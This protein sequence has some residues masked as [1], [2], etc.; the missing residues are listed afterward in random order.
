[1][2]VNCHP[3]G[4][5]LSGPKD[6]SDLRDLREASRSLRRNNRA[7][8][9]LPYCDFV[10]YCDH[11]QGGGKYDAKLSQSRALR[12]VYRA[13]GSVSHRLLVFSS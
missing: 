1:M 6:L 7:F 12:A 3:E 8:G 9:S 10:G 11:N 13:F 5:A 2:F 4:R